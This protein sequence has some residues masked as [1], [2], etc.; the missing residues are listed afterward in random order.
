DLRFGYRS[1]LLPDGWVLTAATLTGAAGDPAALEAGMAEQLAARDASQP[2]RE[3]SA[4]STFRNPSG[5]SSTG[6]AD[7]THELKAWSL[8]DRAGL[9]GATLGGAQ[10]S[11]MH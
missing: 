11:A 8:I 2:T 4:G 10:M 5:G 1:S 9:R 7:D 6:R 3:R